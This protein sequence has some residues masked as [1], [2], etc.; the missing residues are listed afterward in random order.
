MPEGALLRTTCDVSLE[1]V[2]RVYGDPLLGRRR[3][4]NQGSGVAN[5]VNEVVVERWGNR[6]DTSGVTQRVV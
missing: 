4:R 5:L 3:A 2:V 1:T 6:S